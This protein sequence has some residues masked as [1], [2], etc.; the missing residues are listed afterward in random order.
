MGSMSSMRIKYMPSII[1]EDKPFLKDK[2][3][4]NSDVA[5]HYNE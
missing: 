5:S 4:K 2:N 1:E 3:I